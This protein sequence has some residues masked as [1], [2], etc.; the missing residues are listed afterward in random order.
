MGSCKAIGIEIFEE[1]GPLI[2]KFR[3]R[4]CSG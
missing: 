2:H 4:I 1:V 3:G